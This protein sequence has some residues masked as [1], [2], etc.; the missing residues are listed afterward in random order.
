[1]TTA[2]LVFYSTHNR[3]RLESIL[4]NQG[5][6]LYLISGRLPDAT[7][8]VRRH[9]ADLVVIDKDVADISV[10]QAVRHI[11]QILPHSP[12]FTASA[13]HQRAEVYRK[14]RHVGTVSLG[15]ILHF[16]AGAELNQWF[17]DQPKLARRTP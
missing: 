5:I 7:E 11:A 4:R 3:D 17:T 16:A 2:L 13:N 10:T 15:E 14:G 6:E 8:T 9:P 12:I 1:M